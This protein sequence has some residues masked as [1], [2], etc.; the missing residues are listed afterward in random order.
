MVY[1][2]LPAIL[3]GR[4]LRPADLEREQVR[5]PRVGDLGERADAGRVARADRAARLND[6][7]HADVALAQ[8]FPPDVQDAGVAGERAV[9]DEDRAGVDGHIARR[10]DRAAR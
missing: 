1:P 7:R 8:E 6:K 3:T 5:Q 10:P 2:E 4:D 9:D